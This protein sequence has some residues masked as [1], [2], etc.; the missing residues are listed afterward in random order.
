[1]EGTN[2]NMTALDQWL[3]GTVVKSALMGAAT[4]VTAIQAI[5][6]GEKE[7]AA[8]SLATQQLLEDVTGDPLVKTDGVPEAA[9]GAA[10]V[11]GLR[12][13]VAALTQEMEDL[14]ATGSSAASSR[15]A[16]ERAVAKFSEATRALNV[17][18][19]ASPEEGPLNTT[20]AALLR[21]ALTQLHAELW[22]TVGPRQR[23]LGGQHIALSVLTS[24][25]EE[26]LG[27]HAD[28]KSLGVYKRHNSQAEANHHALLA[29]R[30]QSLSSV[31]GGSA[32]TA[33]GRL[34]EIAMDDAAATNIL[35][36]LDQ[37]WW[38]LRGVLSGYVTLAEQQVRST[39]DMMEGMEA[40]VGCSASYQDL[41]KP[42]AT[43]RAT[44]HASHVAMRRAWSKAAPLLGLFTAT[45]VD[46][47]AFIRL[48][49]RDALSINGSAWL[50]AVRAMRGRSGWKAA[51]DNSQPPC[52]VDGKEAHG[53]LKRLVRTKQMSG[54]AGQT[55]GQASAL[56]SMAKRLRR[57]LMQL[58]GGAAE[59]REVI[60]EPG[61]MLGELRAAFWESLAQ[62]G[63]LQQ[64]AEGLRAD[65]CG[66]PASKTAVKVPALLHEIDDQTSRLHEQSAKLQGQN[67]E[68]LQWDAQLRELQEQSAVLKE[69]KLVGALGLAGLFFW[70]AWRMATAK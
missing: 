6:V 39:I 38:R 23:K 8:T 57:R 34:A 33:S 2:Q 18:S 53:V 44:R 21:T 52:E 29:R 41:A 3:H 68:L 60:E 70:G 5:K 7:L 37:Q 56:F 50:S 14:V 9:S 46:S 19:V 45:V 47:D 1:M 30:A 42:Y 64:L 27:L 59:A 65:V 24:N 28:L 43:A 61:R 63:D 40:Y 67:A 26:L 54:L 4:T 16:A 25:Q 10:D 49:A 13:D 17:R 66:T 51:T 15:A 31:V 55:M 69:V 36:D 11:A 35:L 32:A 62:D 22:H 58:P 48:G 12:A 20:A